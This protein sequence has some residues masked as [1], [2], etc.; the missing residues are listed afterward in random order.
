[1]ARVYDW[2]SLL[3]E[4]HSWALLREVLVG[5]EDAARWSSSVEHNR[6]VVAWGVIV[7]GHLPH[8][9]IGESVFGERFR[10]L[11]QANQV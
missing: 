7:V 11:E 10:A 1:M 8:Q 4:G 6:T 2:R 5:L 9:Q 3:S